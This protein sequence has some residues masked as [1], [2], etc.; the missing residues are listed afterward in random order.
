MD[1]SAASA[2]EFLH[3]VMIVLGQCTEFLGNQDC[4][5]QRIINYYVQKI[6]PILIE[7]RKFYQK[8][9]V[10]DPTTDGCWVQNDLMPCWGWY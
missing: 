8:I 3:N 1:N 6:Q 5:Y 10:G 9:A 7:V 2:L 4:L